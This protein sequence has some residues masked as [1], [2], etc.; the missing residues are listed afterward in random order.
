VAGNV[1]DLD[2]IGAKVVGQ[3][4]QGLDLGDVV[5]LEDLAQRAHG[6]ASVD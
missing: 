5:S 1:E 6:D 2:A 4:E 3:A